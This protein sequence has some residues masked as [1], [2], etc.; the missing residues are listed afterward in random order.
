MDM[1]KYDYENAI[2]CDV[3]DYIKSNGIMQDILDA[4]AQG[5]EALED[6]KDHLD[7]DLFVSEV[8]GNDSDEGYKHEGEFYVSEYLCGNFDLLKD[9]FA[10]LGE[11]T[12]FSAV[13]FDTTIR[14]YLLNWCIDK[15]V[16][17][18]IEGKVSEICSLWVWDEI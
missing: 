7:D 2:C 6:L 5:D 3:L 9:A 8:T 11:P 13:A 12:K 17:K 16:E 18:I 10:H 15:V 1:K 14:C 4:Y